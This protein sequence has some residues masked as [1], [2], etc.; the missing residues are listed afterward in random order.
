MSCDESEAKA[1]AARDERKR[2]PSDLRRRRPGGAS[3]RTAALLAFADRAIARAARQRGQRVSRRSPPRWTRSRAAASCSCWAYRRPL[4]VWA[5]PA[6]SRTRRSS[7]SSAARR[8]HARQRAA[9]RD[10]L[11]PGRLHGRPAGREPRRT[12][13]QDRGQPVAPGYAGRDHRFE[14]ALI[15]GL[16]MMMTAPSSCGAAPSRSPG[17]PSCPSCGALR[18]AGRERR[19]RASLPDRTDARR[20]CWPICG[21]RI[22]ARFPSAKFVSYAT[23]SGDGVVDGTKLAFGRPLVPRHRLRARGDRLARRGLPERRPR[24]DPPVSANLPAGARQAA[25]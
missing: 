25:T 4:S 14:Q 15:L 5:P 6:R 9:L 24:A 16:Y 23:G 13:D 11:C 7:R 1:T 2:V 10:R 3:G 18:R 20:R 22:L 8:G 12:P 21:G 17:R 19:R